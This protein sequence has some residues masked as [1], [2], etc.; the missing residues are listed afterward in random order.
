MITHRDRIVDSF[1]TATSIPNKN[2]QVAI[3]IRRKDSIDKSGRYLPDNHYLNII[4][5]IQQC[6]QDHNITVYSQEVG[7]TP[8]LYR[9]CKIV[10]DV[11]ENDFDTFKKLIHA[12]HLIVGT[13]SFSYAAALLN[14]NTVVYHFQGHVPIKNWISVDDYIKLINK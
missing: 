3:H 8:E 9:D 10:L 7:F 6:K 1:N 13:S 12:D 11:D 14:K 2:T 5:N 4:Q